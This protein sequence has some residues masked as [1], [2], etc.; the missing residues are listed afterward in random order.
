MV[1]QG[2]LLS[3]QIF[4]WDYCKSPT[5]VSPE[6]T[7]LHSYAVRWE[8]DWAA[9]LYGA[10]LGTI[11]QTVDVVCIDF[12]SVFWKSSAVRGQTVFLRDSRVKPDVVLHKVT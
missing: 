10:L 6:I 2:N 9:S 3:F 4:H 1:P 8:V 7:S 5:S 11:Q 12:L